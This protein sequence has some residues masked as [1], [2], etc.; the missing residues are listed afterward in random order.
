MEVM[1]ANDAPAM[2]R[3]LDVLGMQV[4]IVVGA[5]TTGGAY[6]MYRIETPAGVGTP[7]H[8]QSQEDEAFYVLDG[9]FEVMRDGETTLAGPGEYVMIPRGVAH[10][11][12][13]AGDS[14]GRLLGIASPAGH[15]RFFEDVDALAA[16]GAMEMA[17]LL[18][19]CARHGVE[20]LP[21]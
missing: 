19:V 16:T 2:G 6:A 18:A 5:E 11:F 4:E 7:P 1:I 10:A 17:N 3:A 20:I 14:V 12:R 9:A 15:E 13:N 8:V 21:G